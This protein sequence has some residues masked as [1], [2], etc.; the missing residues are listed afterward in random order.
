MCDDRGV[1][2]D[3]RRAAGSP[4][5]PEPITIEFDGPDGPHWLPVIDRPRR[6]EPTGSGWTALGA[7]VAVSLVIAAAVLALDLIGDPAARSAGPARRAE[8]VAP[9]PAE[10]GTLPPAIA[11]ELPYPGGAVPPGRY[12]TELLGIPIEF[13]I[14][15][16]TALRTAR[17]GTVLLTP[18]GTAANDLEGAPHV[19]FVRV[20]GWNTRREAS[21]RRFRGVGS[22]APDDIETW[23]ADNDLL[24]DRRARTTVD[25]RPARVYDLRV[26]P[27]SDLGQDV[28][29]PRLRPCFWF[30]SVAAEVSPHAAIRLDSALYGPTTV[31]LWLIE[32]AGEDPILVEAAAVAGDESWLNDFEAVTITSLEVGESGVE[33]LAGAGSGIPAGG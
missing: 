24:V 5:A 18:V 17:P 2:T 33:M 26:D 27:V 29:S 6:R 20:A 16:A 32:V 28:C 13:T 22:I 25:G 31:R 30:A 23:L 7:I 21:D 11:S 15:T 1:Q 9:L 8:T 19:Q 3:R 4:P 10:S 12:A 14:A